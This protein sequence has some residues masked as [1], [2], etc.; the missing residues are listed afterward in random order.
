MEEEIGSLPADWTNVGSER[1]EVGLLH[2]G[3]G[4]RSRPPKPDVRVAAR[5]AF[6]QRLQLADERRTFGT[7][8]L[9]KRIRIREH[10]GLLQDFVHGFDLDQG[11]VL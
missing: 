9:E 7:P 3:A 8:A 1:D 10:Q 6:H 11:D 2:L 4:S 5:S